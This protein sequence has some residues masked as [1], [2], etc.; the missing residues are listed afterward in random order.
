M[1]SMTLKDAKS[2]VKRF[3]GESIPVKVEDCG[4]YYALA[5]V[6]KNYIALD[7]SFWTYY[8]FLPDEMKR[9]LAHEVGHFNTTCSSQYG[10]ELDTQL[11]AIRRAREM[12]NKRLCALLKAD[13]A[14]WSY[15]KSRTDKRYR[16]ARKSF[17]VK[18][19]RYE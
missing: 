11:W 17:V 3:H 10:W 1:K 4:E 19:M 2:F 16:D 12:G 13:F 14:R 8:K 9:L 15:Y 6:D 18:G 7:P 5:Y